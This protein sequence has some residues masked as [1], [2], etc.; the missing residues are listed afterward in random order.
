[1]LMNEESILAN[2]LIFDIF[3]AKYI[4]RKND[5][6][7]KAIIEHIEEENAKDDQDRHR[8]ELKIGKDNL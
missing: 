3:R 5:E 6:E 1:M 2:L 4:M 7:V 8:I